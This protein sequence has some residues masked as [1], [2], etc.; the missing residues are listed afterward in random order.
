MQHFITEFMLTKR[1]AG[2]S[3]TEEISLTRIPADDS[4]PAGSLAAAESVAAVAITSDLASHQLLRGERLCPDA[5]SS[6]HVF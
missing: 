3:S 1:L 5:D 2:I 6:D 4:A